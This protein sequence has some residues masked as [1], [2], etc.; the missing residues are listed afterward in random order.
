MTCTI[1]LI[2]GLFVGTAFGMLVMCI[3]SVTG[4]GEK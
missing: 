4:G 1:C 3:L 2:I